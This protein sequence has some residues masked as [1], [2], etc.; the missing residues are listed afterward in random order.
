[1]GGYDEV[2]VAQILDMSGLKAPSLY[3][4][5]GDK[6]GLFVSWVSLALEEMK[7]KV[8]PVAFG[9]GDLR[10][11]LKRLAETILDGHTVDVLQVQRDQRLMKNPDSNSRIKR[12][13]DDS[14]YRPVRHVLNEGVERGEM[15]KDEVER[16][17]HLFVHS[18]FS[19][20]PTY[21]METPTE[22][23]FTWLVNIAVSGR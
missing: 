20:H 2:S 12:W 19:L 11:K 7:A 13:I 17:A 22:E 23:N 14:L 10:G 3:H 8:E 16:L 5:F 9:E 21:S 18:V 1:M 6:E 4:H 15:K